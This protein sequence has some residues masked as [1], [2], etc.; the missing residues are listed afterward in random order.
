[1][2]IP[3]VEPNS[4]TAYLAAVVASS[5]D[6][7]IASDLE[8]RITL[9]NPAAQSLLGYTAPDALGMSTLALFPDNAQTL[10]RDALER[11]RKG[12]TIDHLETFLVRNDGTLVD[13][14]ITIS[15]VVNADG[16]VVGVSKI[17]R[18]IGE[19]RRAETAA[20]HLAAIVESSD[21]AIVSK[22]LNGIVMSWNAGAERLFGY[23]ADEMIGQSITK[24]IPSDRLAE[25]A[26]VLS[27]LRAGLRVDHFE[28]VRRTK[29]GEPIDVS[30]TVSPIRNT[31]GRV[32][33]ASKIARDISERKRL[34]EAQRAAL[35][36][37]NQRIQ[38][39]NRL[40]SQFVANMSHELRTPLNAIVGFA[41][42]IADEKF[43]PLPPK[44][45]R[46]GHLMLKSAEHLL[47]LINDI[48]DLAKVESGR[49][50]LKPRDVDVSLIIRDVTSIVSSLAKQRNVSI[51]L[52]VEPGLDDLYLDPDRLKQV[53]YNYLSNAVKF[54][55]EGGRVAVRALAAG[56][57]QFRVEVED[58]GIGIPA[59]DFGRLFVEFQQLDSST[60]KRAMGTGLGLALTK[61]IVEAQGGSVDV[62]SEVGVG[63]TFSATLPRRVYA[64]SA[65]ISSKEH[66]S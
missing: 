15:P 1:M 18:D 53:L 7:I 46:F 28:T 59:E 57:G 40:K 21:D 60:T 52:F 45:A 25:E 3:S 13:V 20:L 32:I 34:V 37:E 41:E 19:R 55:L 48:L 39:A 29:S 2:S 27:Q 58:W 31:S 10:E 17:A 14:A 8:G 65:D 63:S 43:G 6:A 23:T 22:D 51:D 42:L 12:D 4:A 11:A 62:K 56:P 30:L 35:E 16:M 38:E 44:Y 49:I 5:D 24:V 50:D 33:G 47:Q 36:A 54:S 61:R 9:W 66:A 64:G 26:Y